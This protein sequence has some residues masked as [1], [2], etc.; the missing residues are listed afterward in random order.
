MDRLQAITQLLGDLKVDKVHIE[1]WEQN[2]EKD[3]DHLVKINVEK[4]YY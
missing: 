2:E 3:A 1:Y 4:E